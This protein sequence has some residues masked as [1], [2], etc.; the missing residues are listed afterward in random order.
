MGKRATEEQK[1]FA[2]VLYMSGEQ[3][4]VIAEKVGISNQTISKWVAEGGWDKRRAA[5]TISRPEMVNKILQSIDK[6]IENSLEDP[7]AEI[8][9]NQLAK[10]A[11]ALEKLDKKANVVDAIEIFIGFGGWLN[12]RSGIDPAVNAKLIKEINRLQDLYVSDWLG[13]QAE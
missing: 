12:K 1:E 8:N 2:R 9:G 13:S 4:N 10:L 11:A 7:A 6:L 3:Q 5:Q